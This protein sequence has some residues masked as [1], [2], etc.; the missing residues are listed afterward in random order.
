M[1]YIVKSFLEATDLH[2]AHRASVFTFRCHSW[3]HA[4]IFATVSCGMETSPSVIL[5]QTMGPAHQCQLRDASHRVAQ[6]WT[7]KF[8]MRRSTDRISGDSAVRTDQ[9]GRFALAE[10]AFTNTSFMCMTSDLQKI[11]PLDESCNF[12]LR[13]V[14]DH[15]PL[16][17]LNYGTLADCQADCL[18]L[19]LSYEGMP[20]LEMAFTNTLSR[21]QDGS[22]YQTSPPTTVSP[23]L[24]RLPAIG[25]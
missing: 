2:V 17:A 3:P 25:R 1:T 9:R 22:E 24:Q 7:G 10:V 19:S 20:S 15:A 12:D 14:D 4:G 16:P 8:E 18:P 21:P 23:P 11:P 5:I 13:A 6:Q